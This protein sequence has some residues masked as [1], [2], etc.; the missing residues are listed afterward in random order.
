MSLS[1]LKEL[2]K[3]LAK[4]SRAAAWMGLGYVVGFL[5]AGVFPSQV[6]TPH[7]S[8]GIIAIVVGAIYVLAFNAEEERAWAL[9]DCLT[10][11]RIRFV[12]GAITEEEQQIL[13]KNCLKLHGR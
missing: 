9:D 11:A 8:G 5:L 10:N 6:A 3:A 2:Y 4:S 1:D 13:R 7:Q 12:T